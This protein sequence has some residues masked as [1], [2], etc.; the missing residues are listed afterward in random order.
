MT[1]EQAE[2]VKEFRVILGYSWRA[3]HREWCDEY[4]KNTIQKGNQQKGIELC[5]EAMELLNEKI[6]DGWN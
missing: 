3:V 5:N 6:E 4:E 1:R 2:F